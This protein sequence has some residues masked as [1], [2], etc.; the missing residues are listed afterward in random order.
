M[1]DDID[2]YW[3][4]TNIIFNAKKDLIK[5]INDK[6]ISDSYEKILNNFT[7]SKVLELPSLKTA[8]ILQH[9]IYKPLPQNSPKYNEFLIRSAYKGHDQDFIDL[10]SQKIYPIEYLKRCGENIHTTTIKTFNLGFLTHEDLTYNLNSPIM[11]HISPIMSHI[12]IEFKNFLDEYYVVLNNNIENKNFYEYSIKKIFDTFNALKHVE[13]DYN[14]NSQINIL[15]NKLISLY[16]VFKDNH[17]NDILAFHNY[18]TVYDKY[19]YS[20]GTLAKF[21]PEFESIYKKY[22][23]SR[24]A[25]SKEIAQEYA[26]K[27]LLIPWSVQYDYNLIEFKN[28]NTGITTKEIP[29]L[30]HDLKKLKDFKYGPDMSCHIHI[31]RPFSLD[32]NPEEYISLLL[33]MDEKNFV[34]DENIGYGRSEHIDKWARN[35]KTQLYDAIQYYSRVK[36]NDHPDGHFIDEKGMDYIVKQLKNT[37]YPGIRLQDKYPTI[38]FRYPSSQLL[39]TPNKILSNIQYFMSLIQTSKSK[40]V[41]HSKLNDLYIVLAKN[42]NES[43]MQIF[44]DG[45][46][47]SRLKPEMKQLIKSNI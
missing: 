20:G 13:I 35:V 23:E 36:F 9:A 43:G 39:Q 1:N 10:L 21:F 5:N 16:L 11:S 6:D 34:K 2:Q 14:K 31:D 18:L 8:N 15:K 30:L 33:L 37:S 29:H 19:Q 22:Y 25:D 3:I 24:S 7:K 28:K 47:K 45:Y 41:I 46:D 44:K 27:N 12:R 42:G 38:E 32:T 26:N 17:K 40:K 4:N